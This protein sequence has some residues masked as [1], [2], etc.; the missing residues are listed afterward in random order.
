MPSRPSPATLLGKMPQGWLKNSLIIENARF[1]GVLISAWGFNVRR[2]LFDPKRHK[3][4]GGV[5]WLRR[6]YS[7]FHSGFWTVI[8]AE[9]AQLN[10]WRSAV[11]GALSHCL[12]QLHA[13]FDHRVYDPV[14]AIGLRA[15]QRLIG[16][17][18]GIGHALATLQPVEAEA[19]GDFHAGQ[20]A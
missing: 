7:L 2:G 15:I 13:I 19:G 20:R 10:F 5:K 4:I 18:N 11:I 16:V 17:A 9:T 6:I 14:A 8:D 1:V 3:L 12:H